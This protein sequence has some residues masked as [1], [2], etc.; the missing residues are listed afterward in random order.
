MSKGITILILIISLNNIISGQII[1]TLID[2]GGYDLHFNIK[3][4]SGL[5]IIFESGAGDDGGIWKNITNALDTL[6]DA[7]LITYDRSGFGKSGYLDDDLNIKQEII[8][9]ENSLRKL[10]YLKPC[11]LVAHSYGGFCALLFAARNHELTKGY[12]AIDANLPCTF[13]KGRV[14]LV[15]QQF[16]PIRDSLK[17][18]NIGLYNLM[19]SMRE[20]VEIMNNIDLNA[21]LPIF[22]IVAEYQYYDSILTLDCHKKF[23]DISPDREL[24]TATD[25]NHYIFFDNPQLIIEKIIEMYTKQKNN[26]KINEW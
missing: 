12:V 14:D 18:A 16:D 13:H 6:I 19:L 2:A 22:D 26:V 21:N 20:D 1:D 7:T 11:I 24:I 15:Y 23:C 17:A 5:P 8:G 10:G 9:L 25:C 3:H 4:D